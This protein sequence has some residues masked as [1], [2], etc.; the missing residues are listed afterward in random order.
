MRPRVALGRGRG[1]P[2]EFDAGRLH[3]GLSGRHVHDAEAD[4]RPRREESMMLV[5]VAE[6]LDG[7]AVGESEEGKAVLL[8]G[9]AMS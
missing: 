2:E 5:V 4:N 8:D 9:G 6:Y 7:V 3:L 1:P